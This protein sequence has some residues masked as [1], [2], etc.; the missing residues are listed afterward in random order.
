VPERLVLTMRPFAQRLVSA[1]TLA[2]SK[3]PMALWLRP[4]VARLVLSEHSLESVL[5]EQTKCL[6]LPLMQSLMVSPEPVLSSLLS[7]GPALASVVTNS[8]AQQPR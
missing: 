6:A 1:R 5:R 8:S 7:R 4:V 3:E 2:K